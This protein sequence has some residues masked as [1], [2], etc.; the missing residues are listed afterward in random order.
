[1][2]AED[3][4]L[5]CCATNKGSIARGLNTLGHMSCREPQDAPA[6]DQCGGYP[7]LAEGY[8]TLS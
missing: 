6:N 8:I 3:I 7:K 4:I 5:F 2:C 1:M